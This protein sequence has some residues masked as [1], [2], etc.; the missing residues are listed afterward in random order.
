MPG[1][2]TPVSGCPLKRLEVRDG[3]QS[4]IYSSSPPTSVITLTL[5]GERSVNSQTGTLLLLIHQ[6][7]QRML[8]IR[9]TDL[10]RNSP[11]PTEIISIDKQLI[12]LL[13][14][15]HGQDRA[16]LAQFEERRDF[17]VAVCLLK[18]SSFHINESIYSTASP[19]AQVIPRS[20]R[21]G[22]GTT[23]SFGPRLSSIT[24]LPQ[25]SQAYPSTNY[26]SQ[27]EPSFTSLLNSPLPSMSSPGSLGPPIPMSQ[28]EYPPRMNSLPVYTNSPCVSTEPAAMGSQLNP[29]NIFLGSSNTFS[30]KP[31]VGSPLKHSFRPGEPVRHQSMSS[32][33]SDSYADALS[34]PLED[35]T[36]SYG[37]QE[38]MGWPDQ[39]RYPPRHKSTTQEEAAHADI[40]VR[41][42]LRQGHPHVARSE[43]NS[44]GTDAGLDFRDLMPRPRKLPFE[45]RA[46]KQLQAKKAPSKQEPALIEGSTE[47]A[48]GKLRT[49]QRRISYEDHENMSA[50]SITATEATPTHDTVGNATSN[51]ESQT[52][53]ASAVLKCNLEASLSIPTTPATTASTAGTSLPPQSPPAWSWAGLDRPIIFTDSKALQELNQATS[54]LLKQY[55]ADVSSG[56]CELA[57]AQ[58]YMDQIM[59]VR[60]NF[61]YVELKEM[62]RGQWITPV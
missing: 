18:K 5:E 56:G 48:P 27:P 58:F 31:R 54:K 36:W 38:T 13:V 60:R 7:Q 45:A 59:A 19:P 22:V 42:E 29:Y 15:I 23:S 24:P 35:L 61:W 47:D 9:L 21:S 3:L 11:K 10:L 52:D 46:K 34:T 49:K 25:F 43:S 57:S 26:S 51:A 14:R 30:H 62:E 39:S 2:P 33:E 55:E 1:P 40:G 4:R 50:A 37:S 28:P 12:Q 16:I 44:S 17:N 41:T 8:S 20:Q 6:G 32:V 53:A